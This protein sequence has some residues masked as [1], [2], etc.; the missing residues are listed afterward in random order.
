MKPIKRLLTRREKGQT[1]IFV[2]VMASVLMGITGVAVEGGH[3][4]VEFRRM[5]AAADM[6]ALVGAQKLPCGLTD[7]S[8]IGAAVSQACDYAKNNGYG[9]GG[10]TGGCL[11]GTKSTGY[12]DTTTTVTA[13][14]PPSS[15][16]PYDFLD[17]GNN[18]ICPGRAASAVNQY[19]FIEVRIQEPVTVPIFNVSFTLSAHAVAKEGV[20]SPSDFAV[21]V[22]DPPPS[23]G[24]LTMGGSGNVIVVGD[25]MSNG[26]IT[27]NG[28]GGKQDSCDGSWFTGAAQNVPGNS[29]FVSDLSGSP[30]FANADCNGGTTLQPASFFPNSPIIP[31][32][33]GDT[34]TPTLALMPGCRPSCDPTNRAWYFDRNT[35]TWQQVSSGSVLKLKASDSFELFPGLYPNGIDATAGGSIYLNPGVYTMGANFKTNGGA[36]MCIFGSPACDRTDSAPSGIPDIPGTN[37]KCANAT[38]TPNDP[39]NSNYIPSATW[40]Y[41]CSPWG[42]WDNQ[43][44]DGRPTDSVP[45]APPTFY[46]P[47]GTTQQPMN[48]V[49]F[50]MKNNASFNMNGN[51]SSFV[52]FPN[53]CPGTGTSWTAGGTAVPFQAN[54]IGEPSGQKDAVYTYPTDSVAYTE[55]NG[56]LQN[57]GQVQA[58]GNKTQVYPSVDLTLEGEINCQNGLQAW[59]NEFPNKGTKGQHLEFVVFAND[60]SESMQLNGSSLQE[61]YGIMHTFPQNYSGYPGPPTSGG[62]N[63]S[64]DI[65]ITGN[66]G[67]A[68][69]GPPFLVGQLVSG[70]ATFSGNGSIEIFYRPCRALKTPCGTG[71]GTAL[72]Q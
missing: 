41:Y 62:C 43:N 47:N 69:N 52:A 45:L 5:Q 7:N 55:S 59:Q 11:T 16:S 17:Y 3:M 67:S 14:V 36:T 64:C 54:P 56:S 44:H 60:P 32:P 50:Y 2:A 49:T 22:L 53:G 6:A 4:F 1:L 8:C 68:Q 72:V 48:G 71:P 38:F 46:D 13:T 29:T 37:F 35:K 63:G 40:Y 21:S 20:S 23:G 12:G 9:G 15:C 10:G 33:Y 42:V 39:N 57:S 51:A 65:K 58:G 26:P 30:Y 25:T 18:S 61:W 27:V 28:N 66:G 19:V 24:G 31:D 70:T 34:A